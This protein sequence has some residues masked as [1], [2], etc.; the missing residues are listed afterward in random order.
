MEQ[1]YV[2]LRNAEKQHRVCSNVH[3]SCFTGL[4][5]VEYITARAAHCSARHTSPCC[6]CGPL[7][8]VGKVILDKGYCILS[9]AFKQASP[10]VK[11]TAERARQKFL[12]MPLVAVRVGDPEKG[13][14]FSILM[15]M[16]SGMDYSKIGLILN[17]FVLDQSATKGGILEKSVV[18][19][20]L[21][22]TES[23][24]ERK[25]LRYAIFKSSGMTPTAIRRRYGFEHM[26]VRAE[27]VE[28]T[29]S[30]IQQIHE[31]ISEL[32]SIEDKALIQSF[33]LAE[34]DLSSE[35]ES[36]VEEGNEVLEP[37]V[38][39]VSADIKEMLRRYNFNWFELI[40]NLKSQMQQD[41]SSTMLAQLYESLSKCDF[42]SD[43]VSLLR[44]SYQAF[45]AAEEDVYEQERTA[46]AVN[47]EIVSES[48]SD[49]PES[50]TT[51]SD[52]LSTAGK[53]LIE[54]K[55]MMIKRR[56]RRRLEKA[57]ANERFLCRRV[58]K[59]ANRILQKFPDVGETIEKFVEE[60]QVG[61]DAWRRTGVLTFDG[62]TKIENKVTYEKIR[63]HLQDT[64]QH[65]F[66]YGTVIQ[67]CVPRNKRRQSAKSY[68]GVAK[69]T[70]RRA[71]KGFNLRLNPDEH[72]SAALYSGLTKLEYVDG[73]NLVNINRDDSTGFRL[74]TLTTCSQYKTPI[75]QGRE[76]LTTRTDYVNKHPSLLQTTSYNF[77]KTNTTGE[78]C[79]GV[80]K[81]FPLHQKN[82]A[83]HFADLCMLES[84]EELKPVFLNLQSGLPKAIECVRVDGATDERPAH[85]EVQ[86]W[87]T[88]R[89][90]SRGRLATLVT[91]RSSGSSYLN[92]VEL[93]NGCLSLGHANTFIPSTL[94]GSSIDPETGVINEGILK[95]NLNLAI[96]AYINRV[97]GCPC[98]DTNIHLYRGADAAD[99]EHLQTRVNLI[100]FLKGSRAAKY[101][102]RQDHP[103]LYAEF[104]SIWDVRRRH[105]VHELPNQYMFFLLCCY[106]PGCMYPI[107]KKGKPSSVAV[108]YDGGPPIT[109]VPFL[110]P[111]SSRPWGNTSCDT[112]KGFC[113]GHYE[114]KFVDTSD[115]SALGAC[116]PPP[117]TVLK[118][119]FAMLREY[120]PSEEYLENISQKVLL[121]PN[122][123]RMWMD[124]L[125]T[126]L[127][128]RKRG[129]R[130]AATTRQARKQA[131]ANLDSQSPRTATNSQYHCGK[132]GKEYAEESDEEEL[133]IACDM[134]NNWFCGRCEG[135][136]SPPVT[137]IYI[138]TKC[139]H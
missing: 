80:V 23:D 61:A 11:Y 130:K 86:Y 97:N 56:S 8:T 4:S 136:Q 133:W 54:K 106:E 125:H 118:K 25:C 102:L 31:A 9:K 49:T 72:W 62:N 27:D 85:A 48:E 30:K 47:G 17:G 35:E 120:P 98:G 3:V 21:S 101:K 2:H 74:D 108:W 110:V 34:I 123:T 81:A 5:L 18:K 107:C 122:V 55:R 137:D 112:C 132:C 41:F 6:V 73:R 40:E 117:S 87:W 37:L 57:I 131:V 115:K 67:L 60:H 116:I 121:T 28:Q 46:R 91:T 64:Y 15:E 52:P 10:T 12:Q 22:I 88:K 84:K 100:T 59:R 65:K 135:L 43:E 77:S 82:P 70:S 32:A 128:N 26:S 126:V 58:S 78:V 138:C 104:E 79:V 75:V 95:Q 50:Y 16:L 19:L 129:A 33:G 76:V 24:R 119:E 14:S 103:Q 94:A 111:D 124:H 68:A 93:Q 71:R 44:Q 139:V 114:V 134:C 53:K 29:L 1:K 13:H 45:C 109:H 92:R 83:Q 90:I 89:H 63:Q 20:L 51:V 36:D 38:L 105:L 66:S 127:Q 69:V 39:P 96:A 7:I 99:S 42:D 113:A